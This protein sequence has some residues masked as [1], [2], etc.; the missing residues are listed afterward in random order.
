[1]KRLIVLL[2]LLIFVVVGGILW[3]K[4]GIS[5]VNSQSKESLIFVVAKGDGVKEISNRLKANGLIR[6]SIVFFLLVK[7]SGIDK[8]I[9]AGDFRFS[10][11]MAAKE[12][13]ENLTHGSTDI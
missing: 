2:T 1:M 8:K 9:E 3:W 12:I 11:S 6:S 4:N 10:P 5:P 13:T 7:Q